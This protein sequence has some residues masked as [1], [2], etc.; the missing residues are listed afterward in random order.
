MDTGPAVEFVVVW[1]PP[2]T[3]LQKW[4]APVAPIEQRGHTTATVW[5]RCWWA[6]HRTDDC[7]LAVRQGLPSQWGQCQ[8]P[9]TGWNLLTRTMT[10][11]CACQRRRMSLCESTDFTL[12]KQT[13]RACLKAAEK[14][15]RIWWIVTQHHKRVMSELR[16]CPVA[17]FQISTYMVRRSSAHSWG[18]VRCFAISPFAEEE[19]TI[20]VGGYDPNNSPS[21]HTAFIFKCRPE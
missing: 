8:S 7:I 18:G 5:S 14:E 19:G 15:M 12:S 20:Y 17:L 21:E 11:A 2:T 6:V 16:Q 4:A 3:P 9:R 1:M 10:C 13:C